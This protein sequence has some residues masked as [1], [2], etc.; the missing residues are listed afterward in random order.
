LAQKHHLNTQNA[1]KPSISHSKSSK[2]TIFILKITQKARIS[3]QNDPKPTHTPAVP[4]P[5]PPALIN[6]QLYPFLTHFNSQNGP[7]TSI[8]AQ[9][10]HF[11]TQNAPKTSILTLK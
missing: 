1:P 9:K 11:Y 5:P 4:S 10:H 8:L 7:K 3:P 2:N 6:T